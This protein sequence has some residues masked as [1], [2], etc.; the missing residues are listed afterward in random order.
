[1][2]KR[3][4]VCSSRVRSRFG[5]CNGQLGVAVQQRRLRPAG[6]VLGGQDQLEPDGV[7][8]PGVKRQ[9]GQP[10][11]LGRADAVLDAGVLTVDQLQPGQAAAV[12]VGTKTW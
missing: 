12:L 10:G 5:L 7:A 2:S 8:T 1:M 9:V 3:P 4:A 11:G 6:Q